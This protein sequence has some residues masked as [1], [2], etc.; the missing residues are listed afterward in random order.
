MKTREQ[1]RP[2]CESLRARQVDGE[3]LDAASEA[4]RLRG[5]GLSVVETGV[6]LAEGFGMRPVDAQELLLRLAVS[7]EDHFA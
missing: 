3:Q 2:E 6:V 7:G 1:L 4:L 5:S